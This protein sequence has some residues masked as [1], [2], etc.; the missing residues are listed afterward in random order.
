[1]PSSSPAAQASTTIPS[2]ETSGPSAVP[3]GP[4]SAA[5][6]LQLARADNTT[7]APTLRP[8]RQ[9]SPVPSTSPSKLLSEPPSRAV[10]LLTTAPAWSLS[11]EP[12]VVDTR[13]PAWIRS[14]LD[15]VS[16][17]ESDSALSPS[18]SVAM[19]MPS[20]LSPSVGQ[21]APGKGTSEAPTLRGQESPRSSVPQTVRPSP[22]AAA[23]STA[24]VLPV[25]SPAP[26]LSL[27]SVPVLSGSVNAASIYFELDGDI[28]YM[29][30]G[31]RAINTLLHRI[32]G[33]LTLDVSS[34]Q[35]ELTSG[36]IGLH[37]LILANRRDLPELVS[38][39]VKSAQAGDYRLDF[40]PFTLLHVGT[41][42][43]SASAGIP[44]T[45]TYKASRSPSHWSTGTVVPS[46]TMVP[47]TVVAAPG[48]LNLNLAAES[49][50]SPV[51]FFAAPSLNEQA[52]NSVWPPIVGGTHSR[53]TDRRE[54]VDSSERNRWNLSWQVLQR[55]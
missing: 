42:P 17:S 28:Q 36:S 21:Q 27:S 34:L 19:A 52:S 6:S 23:V 4:T 44:A 55:L 50:V 35:L 45:S 38:S 22:G 12:V 13:S 46:P 53:H 47:L 5:P 37:L 8:S 31:G 43:F 14:A 32:A 9:F 10:S 24:A 20:P 1:V 33:I 7:Q 51:S 18:P 25:R 15:G 49:S 11:V 2:S 16:V 3:S 30:L 39:F 54:D 40:A 26:K 29:Q 41:S 48:S